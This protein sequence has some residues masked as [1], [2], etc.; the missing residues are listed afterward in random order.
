MAKRKRYIKGI[1]NLFS[2]LNI[3]TSEWSILVVNCVVLWSL[4]YFL[5]I[6]LSLVL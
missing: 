4:S 3:V 6:S 5:I 2:V 1:L